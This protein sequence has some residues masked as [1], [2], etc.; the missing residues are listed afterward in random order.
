MVMSGGEFVAL[1]T[2]ADGPTYDELTRNPIVQ[3]DG[4]LATVWAEYQVIVDGTLSHCGSDAI[5]LVR[6]G[7]QWKILHL[8]D[9]FRREGCGPRW[10]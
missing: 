6:L 9:T 3:Q 4:D 10:R 1:T 2:K 5:H 7:G 8:S